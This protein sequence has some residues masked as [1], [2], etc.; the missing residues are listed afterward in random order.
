LAFPQWPCYIELVVVGTK[1]LS[2]MKMLL[3]WKKKPSWHSMNVPLRHVQYGKTDIIFIKSHTFCKHRKTNWLR[4]Q[5]SIA[6]MQH[7]TSFYHLVIIWTRRSILYPLL[8]LVNKSIN[9]W[10]FSYWPCHTPLVLIMASDGCNGPRRCP[11]PL[12]MN[13]LLFV[14]HVNI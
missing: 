7:R 5:W 1:K 14:I 12:Q 4:V 3:N 13:C 11:G 8:K 2:T 6:G 10:P 9:I